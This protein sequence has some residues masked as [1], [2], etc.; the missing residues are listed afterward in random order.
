MLKSSVAV[1]DI[2]SGLKSYLLIT[3]EIV[4]RGE[5]TATAPCIGDILNT[6]AS[7]DICSA[8]SD[9]IYGPPTAIIVQILVD[10]LEIISTLRVEGN[11]SNIR[12]VDELQKLL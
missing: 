4:I 6:V 5:S 1:T 8:N 12:L 11:V 9:T 7:H 10:T 2:S 3:G